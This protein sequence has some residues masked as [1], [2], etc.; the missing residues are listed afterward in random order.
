MLK[1][2]KREVRINNI[3]TD[4]CEQWGVF[5]QVGSGYCIYSVGIPVDNHILILHIAMQ[6]T[7]YFNL[8]GIIYN[9]NTQYN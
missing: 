6:R 8:S 7:L 3:S 9:N 2:V 5:R 4:A 1:E